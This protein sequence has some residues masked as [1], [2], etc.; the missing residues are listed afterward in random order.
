MKLTK[1]QSSG[2]DHLVASISEIESSSSLNW[3]FI[4]RAMCDRS[5]PFGAD[6][7]VVVSQTDT[8][9]SSCEIENFTPD[10]NR[11][12]LCINGI[13]C[14]ASAISWGIGTKIERTTTIV[15]QEYHLASEAIGNGGI[16]RSEFGR[17]TIKSSCAS[18]FVTITE[19][20][21]K[22]VLNEIGIKFE[23]I[24]W[25][26]VGTPQLHFS[27]PSVEESKLERLGVVLNERRIAPNGLNVSAV[28]IQGNR[29]LTRTF[30]RGGAGMTY[31]CASASSCSAAFAAKALQFPGEQYTV[32]TK[33]GEFSV[34]IKQDGDDF[35]V[36][37]ISGVVSPVYS[38]EVT[39]EYLSKLAS[40][41]SSVSKIVGSLYMESISE[42]DALLHDVLSGAKFSEWCK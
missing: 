15:E 26:D 12:G 27:S 32:V 2:S 11:P 22:D 6:G 39:T 18:D 28:K 19:Q 16:F 40:S 13:L 1:F 10:G 17:F 37:R 8:K 23:G 25:Y 42:H 4:A 36:S 35:V 24:A 30:E 21:V 20:A 3:P 14:A 41:Q 29:V 38:T 34:N 33:G 7:L 31:S 9:D 5:G